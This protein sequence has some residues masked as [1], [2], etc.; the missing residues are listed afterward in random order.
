MTRC[1]LYPARCGVPSWRFP[2]AGPLRFPSA[3]RSAAARA[4]SAPTPPLCCLRVAFHSPFRQRTDVDGRAVGYH[5]A[6]GDVASMS[7]SCST[8]S[9]R[10]RLPAGGRRRAVELGCAGWR[11]FSSGGHI[12]HRIL[13]GLQG[14][15]N[16]LSLLLAAAL[17]GMHHQYLLQRWRRR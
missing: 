16:T 9:A 17:P 3:V 15:C 10:T 12:V 7:P 6:G 4:H 5:V 8:A 11:T 1:F 2:S 13:A 14:V